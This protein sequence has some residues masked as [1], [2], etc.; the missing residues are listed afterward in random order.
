VEFVKTMSVEEVR[1]RLRSGRAYSAL[2][3]DDSVTG[4][5]RDLLDQASDAGC[6]VIVVDSGRAPH[7]WVDVGASGILHLQFTPADLLQVLSQVAAPI[8]AVTAEGAALN[9]SHEPGH[10]GFRGHLV[11]VTGSGGTGTSTV[12]M[13]VAQGLAQDP[14]RTGLVCLADL[15]LHAEQAML[16]GSPDVVPGLTELVEAHRAGIPTIE[17]VRALTWE[18]PERGYHLL[19]GLR[20]HRDWTALRPRTFEA[21]LDG[22]RRGFRVVVADTDPDVEGEAATGSTDV[23][24]RNLLARTTL[25]AADV[26]LVVGGPEMKGL[27]SLLRTTR[28]LLELGVAPE[29]LVPLVNRAP[30][31]PKGRASLTR[32]FADLLA[33]SS[34][35]ASVPAPIFLAPRHHLDHVLRDGSRLPD[36]WLAAVAGSVHA[37]LERVDRSPSPV[38]ATVE[39]LPVSPGSLGSWTMDE[40]EPGSEAS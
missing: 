9:P 4:L 30:K 22:L 21:A 38:G 12:A 15:A 35:A 2:L 18:V 26:A 24:E 37:V 23:E 3:I 5:D 20:R 14:R 6:A 7:R 13:A 40:D 34:G 31:S 17:A 29:R 27:H 11:A 19:L 32:A 8:T 25:A 10:S 16:H 1:T 28:D 36:S 39:P 33:A